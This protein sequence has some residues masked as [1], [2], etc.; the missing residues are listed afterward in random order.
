MGLQHLRARANAGFE[1]KGQALL[2]ALWHSQMLAKEQSVTAFGQLLGR[3][4]GRVRHP[5]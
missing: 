5:A 3:L 4:N 2:I 1:I